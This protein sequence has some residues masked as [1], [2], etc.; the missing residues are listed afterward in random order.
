MPAPPSTSCFLC[1]QCDIIYSDPHTRCA[2]GLHEGFAI[3][4]LCAAVR[5]SPKW[6]FVRVFWSLLC[7]TSEANA[8]ALAGSA[9][10]LIP[11]CLHRTPALLFQIS[12]EGRFLN[13]KCGCRPFHIQTFTSLET[14]SRYTTT[15][16]KCPIQVLS[17]QHAVKIGD[18]KVARFVTERVRVHC[19][20]LTDKQNH[21]TRAK[22]VKV[23]ESCTV[24]IAGHMGTAL[25]WLRVY[26]VRG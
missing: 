2:S 11:R 25:Q 21:E 15:F 26:V 8:S 16:L 24:R 7:T 20:I 13:K 17:E 4:R 10:L 1:F 14:P 18:D 5:G 9:C 23:G 3:V 22:H 12:S 19:W 6:L